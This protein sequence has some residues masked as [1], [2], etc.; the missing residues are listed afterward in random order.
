MNLVLGIDGGGTK[1]LAWLAAAEGDAAPLGVGLG[2]PGNFQAVGVEAALANLSASI[3]AAFADAKLQRGPVA[4]AVV[5]LAGSDREENRKILA[6]WASVRNLSHRFRV[7]NDALPIVAAGS[8]EGWGIGLI[9]GTGSL[10]FGQT[11]DGRQ[12]RSGGWGYLFG[13]EGS[14]YALGVAG[15]RAA[16]KAADGRGPKTRLLE[17]FLKHFQISS[18]ADLVRAAYPLAGDRAQIASLAS[19]VSE[20]AARSD[21]VAQ[22]IFDTAAAELAAMVRAVAQ[23]LD[24]D[25]A[26]FPLALTGGVLCAN[27]TLRRSLEEH[28]QRLDLT[29]EPVTTVEQPVAGAVRLA[30]IELRAN[31]PQ[32]ASLE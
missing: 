5:G 14:A 11:A 18:P 24:L 29:P 12:A 1:T 23:S 25:G 26:T 27:A 4:A 20:A 3:D 9:S 13:D 31:P 32:E 8:P 15:L 19:I 22:A 7:V 28:L 21:G 10:C 17:G 2:G 30:Q 16:A 6:D